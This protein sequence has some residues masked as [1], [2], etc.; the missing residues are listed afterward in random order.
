MTYQLVFIEV[1][2]NEAG[3]R[4]VSCGVSVQTDRGSCTQGKSDEAHTQKNGWRC[5][6][7]IRMVLD[8]P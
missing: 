8:G 3:F 5:D 2:L 7:V 4:V 6:V 1:G